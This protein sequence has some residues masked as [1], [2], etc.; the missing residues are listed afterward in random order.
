MKTP[1]RG[2]H[3]RR[4]ERQADENREHDNGHIEGAVGAA[5][6]EPVEQDAH[7]RGDARVAADRDAQQRIQVALVLHRHPVA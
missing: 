1:Y 3:G 5:R 4:A 2:V 6:I 7:D